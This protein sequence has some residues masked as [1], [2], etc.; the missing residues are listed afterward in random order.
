MDAVRDKLRE[1]KIKL[2]LP[3]YDT[4]DAV[5][6]LAKTYAGALEVPEAEVKAHLEALRQSALEKL[7]ARTLITLQGAGF[8]VRESIELPGAVA[9]AAVAAAL[10]HDTRAQHVRIVGGGR[11]LRDAETL[12]E[13]GWPAGAALRCVVACTPRTEDVVDPDAVAAH[14]RQ[15]VLEACD[16]LANDQHFSLSDGGSGRRV[17]VHQAARAPL[18][19]ALCCHARGRQALGDGLSGGSRAVDAVSWLREADD[20]F[21]VAVAM[22]PGLEDLANL[23]FLQLDLVRGYCALGD[24][25]AIDDAD[26]R[27]A[28]ARAALVKRYDAVFESRG[29]DAARRGRKVPAAFVSLARL[30]VLE[31]VAARARGQA[32]ADRIRDADAI[33]VAL[34]HSDAAIR[35]LQ[36]LG[37]S[38]SAARGALRRAEGNSSRAAEELMERA[39]RVAANRARPAALADEM[40]AD[41]SLID[42]ESLSRV[43]RGAKRA[44]ESARLDAL[45]RHRN[46]ADAAI[47][48]LTAPVDPTALASLVSM[49][50]EVDAAEEA[51]RATNGNVDAAATRLLEAPPPF[52]PKAPPPPD[53]PTDDEDRDAALVAARDLVERELGGALAG[54]DADAEE[55][56]DLRF[57]RRLLDMLISGRWEN[58]CVRQTTVLVS[59]KVT[60]PRRPTAA[61]VAAPT[62]AAPAWAP[63]AAA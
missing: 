20:A 53:L 46:D 61:P 58:A 32:D 59:H 42:A 43:R 17:S 30:L 28:A 56:C 60:P 24:A 25:S 27:L 44:S 12:R 19:R 10:G 49:G 40:T 4:P 8:S 2:W 9:R 63:W 11:A 35:P 1:D 51:L 26:R 47:A 52:Q 21:G 54:A 41:G 62:A 34:E 57:E 15:R 7:A 22:S 18:V 39:G 31:C 33:M 36:E 5:D 14:E 50:A 55:G 13:Q 29:V 48:E 6:A 23:G 37:H 16:V 3:P 38:L 45:K